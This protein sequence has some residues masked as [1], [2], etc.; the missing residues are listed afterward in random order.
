MKETI[1][2]VSKNNKNNFKKTIIREDIK[3]TFYI[4]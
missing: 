3:Y 2:T 4:K 1:N